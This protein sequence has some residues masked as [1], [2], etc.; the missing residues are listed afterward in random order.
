M[1][2]V[3]TGGMMLKTQL[4][5]TWINYILKDIQFKNQYFKLQ[6]FTILLVLLYF[7]SNKYPKYSR[8]CSCSLLRYTSVTK[9]GRKMI[10]VQRSTGLTLA[11]FTTGQRWRKSHQTKTERETSRCSQSCLSSLFTVCL[12]PA[13][14]PRRAGH[15]SAYRNSPPMQTDLLS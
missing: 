4:C 12:C 6:Y 7:W 3:K 13:T 9:R 8:N 2:H 14:V 11:S 5:I 15:W 1:T 10:T